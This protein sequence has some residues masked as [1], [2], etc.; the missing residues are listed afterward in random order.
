MTKQTVVHI[1]GQEVSIT[2]TKAGNASASKAQL[3]ALD[4]VLTIQGG[5]S[6]YNYLHAEYAK[7]SQEERNALGVVSM[8]HAVVHDGRT[9]QEHANEALVEY[10]AGDGIEDLRLR[11]IMNSVN[12]PAVP[13]V[14]V[15][16]DPNPA[17]ATPG[18]TNELPKVAMVDCDGNIVDTQ[19][20]GTLCYTCAVQQANEQAPTTEGA[21]NTQ[22]EELNM[23]K[24]QVEEVI[25]RLKG[26]ATE[27][28]P[29][30]KEENKLVVT[31]KAYAIRT[32]DAI[33]A[34]FKSVKE[35][36]Y[37]SLVTGAKG[38]LAKVYDWTNTSA[39]GRFTK[40]TV[41][42]ALASV[43]FG[44]FVSSGSI[45]INAITVALGAGLVVGA[46]NVLRHNPECTFNE[47]A[48]TVAKGL[49][50]GI[51]FVAAAWVVAPLV[52]AA[53]AYAANTVLFAIAHSFVIVFA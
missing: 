29:A 11:A 39:V 22:M 32:W 43:A 47:Y 25:E 49:A 46:Y 12:L 48:I 24:K 7:L 30:V 42:V 8:A 27:E 4:T 53:V 5:N 23:E 37:K 14:P 16:A 40:G 9:A 33:K 44:C 41:K 36:D 2:L 50:S 35:Y 3:K 31:T 21:N 52:F 20:T 19:Y 38:M 51:A 10:M 13:E 18:C 34:A 26:A 45:L 17:C 1:N 28:A 15:Q 6:E